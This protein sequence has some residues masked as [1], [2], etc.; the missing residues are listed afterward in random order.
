MVSDFIN[1]KCLYTGN[2]MNVEYIA[3]IGNNH[4]GDL[5][6]AKE[7]ADA[8]IE[9]NADYVKFQ[10]Y[11]IDKFISSTNPY[12]NDFITES[13][14]FEAFVELKEYIEKKGGTFLA[15]PFDEDSLEFLSELG[16]KTFKIA[17]GDMNNFQ[18]LAQ[19]TKKGECLFLSVGGANLDEIDATANFIKAKKIELVILHC[20]INYPA[21]FSE[22]N[23]N[24][25]RTLINRYDCPIGYSDH[26]VGIEGSLAAIAL[27][28]KLIE[29]HFTIDRLLPGGDN[30]MSVLPVEFER[31]THEG[32]NIAKAI[33]SEQKNLS[34]DE[35]K[36]KKLIR[37]EFFAKKNIAKGSMVSDDDL[38][39]LRP[40]IPGLGFGAEYYS[41]LI[42]STAI[43]DI[44][45][46]MIVT[47]KCINV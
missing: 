26:S 47:K 25:I 14:Q 32:S 8:A 19:A 30:E 24:F 5:S 43:E 33:G 44:K 15:T 4:K 45:K 39:L 27:G 34:I 9:A 2:P 46:G 22:L 6:L 7:M 21:R 37:R 12:Y 17:S 36:I 31:L 42:G 41:R 1:Q 28:A 16:M 18:L 35:K 29:K 40:S 13:L 10:I 20:I 38:L 23:L 11:N 3:E